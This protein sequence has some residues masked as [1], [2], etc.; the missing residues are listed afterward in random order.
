MAA[1]PS[2]RTHMQMRMLYETTGQTPEALAAA[3]E[4]ET[5]DNLQAGAARV[6]A[7]AGEAVAATREALEGKVGDLETTTTDLSADR[8]RLDREI[9][10]VT[11]GIE[12]REAGLAAMRGTTAVAYAHM[13][14][15]IQE[16]KKAQATLIAARA[17]LSH[18]GASPYYEGTR[19]AVVYGE[20]ASSRI[21][22]ERWK[23]NH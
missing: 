14:A 22:D 5:T 15:S 13:L 2:M 10:A 4:R 3:V 12:D 11:A 16:L 1:V 20:G 17:A 19:G 8:E 6:A 23:S 21:E 18:P 7:A 9:T